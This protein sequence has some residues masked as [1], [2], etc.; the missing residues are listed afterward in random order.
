MQVF[1]TFFVNLN[2]DYNILAFPN[3]PVNHR[4]TFHH[5]ILFLI[6]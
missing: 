2:F 3:I 1:K 6:M 5:K 4:V